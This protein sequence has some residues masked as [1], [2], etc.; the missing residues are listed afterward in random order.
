MEKFKKREL[1]QESFFSNDDGIEINKLLSLVKG[2]EYYSNILN[3]FN[4][5][6]DS[7]EK[8]DIK[9]ARTLY[10]IL[11]SIDE[12]YIKIDLK[13]D[14]KDIYF[15]YTKGFSIRFSDLSTNHYLKEITEEELVAIPVHSAERDFF[16]N[17]YEI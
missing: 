15:D 17:L 12:N 4:I 9:G 8:I 3:Y 2:H 5:D 16:S 1:K 14:L 10:A 11:K 6:E 7:Q 13:S